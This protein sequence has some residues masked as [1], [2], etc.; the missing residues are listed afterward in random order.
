MKSNQPIRKIL[1]IKPR[2]AGDVLLSTPVAANLRNTFPNAM[3]TFLTERGGAEILRGSPWVDEVL[4]LEPGFFSR[5][6]LI[7]RLRK[8]RFDLVF[9]LFANPGTALFTLLTGARLRIGYALRFRRFGYTLAVR[10]R[11]GEVHNTDFNLDALRALGIEPGKI[12]PQVFLDDEERRFAAQFLRSQH[13]G[14]R[15]VGLSI[16]GGW[17]TKRWRPLSFIELGRRIVRE[18]DASV[19]IL[20]GPDEA[21]EAAM[22]A[23]GIGERSVLPPCTS[24]RELAALAEACDVVISNDTGP[25]HIAA[26]VGTPVLAIFGPT[27]PELQG[28]VG[29]SHAVVR[30]E[31]LE[32]LGCNLTKCPIGNIC[33]TELTPERVYEAYLELSHDVAAEA[34]PAARIHEEDQ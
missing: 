24:L 14:A 13:A 16:G 3:I 17:E 28:P 25:M 9:D 4:L 12:P 31:S 10:P 5:A 15:M 29:A 34:Q 2:A 23:E 26:A 22:I 21:E 6:R 20:Y 33:M 8:E 7:G 27:R 19:I 18:E 1:I 30:N 32:C 11:G